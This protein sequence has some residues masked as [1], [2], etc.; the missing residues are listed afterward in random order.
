MSFDPEEF[1]SM[2]IGPTAPFLIEQQIGLYDL[3]GSLQERFSQ[4]K[5]EVKAGC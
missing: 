3:C 5:L 4:K 2:Q 1:L